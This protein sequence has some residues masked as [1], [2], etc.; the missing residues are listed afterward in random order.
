M[1]YTK[2]NP[3][4]PAKNW[5]TDEQSKCISA[6]NAVLDKG[7]SDEDAIYS[8]IHAAGKSKKEYVVHELVNS[9]LKSISDQVKLPPHT[10]RTR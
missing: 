5:T 10:L 3:L 6:A 1:P 2:D 8:C 7:G 4:R 9:T